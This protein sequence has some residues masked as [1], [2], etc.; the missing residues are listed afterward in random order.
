MLRK[1][2]W[3]LDRPKVHRKVSN[4]MYYSN[5]SYSVSETKIVSVIAP[6]SSSSRSRVPGTFGFFHPLSN[7]LNLPL[8]L[9]YL[10]YSSSLD[11][12]AAALAAISSAAILSFR[13]LA[14]FRCFLCAFSHILKIFFYI[15]DRLPQLE[16]LPYIAVSFKL[17]F[18]LS[19]ANMCYSYIEPSMSA[20]TCVCY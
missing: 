15:L 8:G 4:L 3:H 11:F 18:R 12:S 10:G 20:D 9:P 19:F 17:L 6:S 2:K 13:K 5:V 1:I 14:V 7:S 16:E